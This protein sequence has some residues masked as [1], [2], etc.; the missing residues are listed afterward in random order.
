MRRLGMRAWAWVG[1][2]VFSGLVVLGLGALS[3]FVI[4]LVLAVVL[5]MIFAPVAGLL[6]RYMPAQLASVLVLSRR[7]IR[8]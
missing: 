1:V 7:R 2:F 5:G 3:E 8:P 6:A 4:P